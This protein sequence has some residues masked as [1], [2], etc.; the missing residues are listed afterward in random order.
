M[1]VAQRHASARGP[2]DEV[3]FPVF[4]VALRQPHEASVLD[5][6]ANGLQH[7]RPER[8]EVVDLQLE[9][10]ET[11]PRFQ[12]AGIRQ[13]HRRVGDIAEDPAVEGAHRVRVTLIGL[14]FQDRSPWFDGHQA[15]SNQLGDRG[16]R[17]LAFGDAAGHLKQRSEF[18][19]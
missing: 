11:L 12:R 5:H 18:V 14:H 3:T 16:L 17:N 15:K 6:T 2:R 1:I 9:G 13:P 7:P 10:G 8:A 19:P 4:D